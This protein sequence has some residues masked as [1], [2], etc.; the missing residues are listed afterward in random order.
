MPRFEDMLDRLSGATVFSKLDLHNGYHQIRIRSGDEWKTTFKT[1]AG[2]F[3]WRV[4]PFI[5]CNAPSTFMRLMHEVLKTYINKFCVVYFDDILVYSPS[6]GNHLE[7]LRVIFST[8][9]LHELY[10]NSASKK[11]TSWALLSKLLELK[12]THRKL[13][14]STLGL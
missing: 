1:P 11:C 10:V 13:P 8:L 14:Q 9:K 5:L 2:L 4:M 3:E 6:F 7:H 12:W